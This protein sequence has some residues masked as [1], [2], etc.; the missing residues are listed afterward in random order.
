MSENYKTQI[1]QPRFIPT[2]RNKAHIYGKKRHKLCNVFFGN[3][4]SLK[5]DFWPL[6]DT[7]DYKLIQ[8]EFNILNVLIISMKRCEKFLD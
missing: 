6:T 2:W 8:I 3:Y 4:F 7:K 1:K 5:E